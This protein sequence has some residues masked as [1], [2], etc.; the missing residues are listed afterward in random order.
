[1]PSDLKT[2]KDVFVPKVKKLIEFSPKLN[3]KKGTIHFWMDKR[4]ASEELISEKICMLSELVDHGKQFNMKLC[5][6]NLTSRHDSFAR[7][8]AEIPNLKMTMDIGHGQLLSKENTAF[9]F[10]AHV[11]EKIEHIHVHDNLGG[12]GVKDDLHLP[13]GDGIIDYPKI[14]SILV[15]KGYNSTITMEV[16]PEQMAKTKKLI[17]QYIQ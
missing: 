5:L 13:L 7:Y 14:L 4:W 11:F 6:E 9:G 10:M 17:D 2:L 12:T 16:K 8:F 3:I 1:N 15:E